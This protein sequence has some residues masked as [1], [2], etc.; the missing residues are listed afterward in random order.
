MTNDTSPVPPATPRTLE[1]VGPTEA[2]PSA[3]MIHDSAQALDPMGD[4]ERQAT[5]GIKKNYAKVGSG[6][7]SSL[8]YTYGPGAIMDLPHFTVMPAGLDDWDRVWARRDGIPTIHAPRLLEVVRMMLGNQVGELRPFPRQPNLTAFSREGSDLGVPA[9]VFPQWMRC[10]GCDRLAPISSFNYRNTHPFRTDEAIF[11]HEQCTGRRRR[12][13]TPPGG[14]AKRGRRPVVTAR[15]LLACPDGHLDE[16]PYDW[17]VHEGAHCPKATD[18]PPLYMIDHSGG[19]GAS[20]TI[21]CGA[22]EAQRPM[23]QA[24]GETGRARLPRCRGRFPHLDGFAPDG[25]RL[26]ARLML[27]GA[28]NLWFP[29]LTSIID[30][31]RLDPAERARDDADRIRVALGEQLAEFAGQLNVLRALLK[32]KVDVVAMSDDELAA[33]I[34]LGA[35]PVEGLMRRSGS[36]CRRSVSRGLGVVR[37]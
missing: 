29:A 28:S 18:S 24:Q 1:E 31:P 20:A 37:C 15:Y 11:E 3:R 9:R 2:L 23:N 19:R 12:S 14:R 26:E 7:P 16:F 6:R 34:V 35:A 13:A 33:L 8:L 36:S 25:C 30:M 22:C 21:R 27:V 10:T 17:W 32:D 5:D 4:G